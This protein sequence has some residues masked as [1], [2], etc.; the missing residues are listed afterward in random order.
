MKDCF[1]RTEYDS[2][3]L[4]ASEGH[5]GARNGVCDGRQLQIDDFGFVFYAVVR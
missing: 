2:I 5:S 3:D 1:W 4:G